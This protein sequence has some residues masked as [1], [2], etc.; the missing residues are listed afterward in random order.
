MKRICKKCNIEKELEE[1]VPNKASKDG[2]MW[3]C[4]ECN[5]ISSAKYRAKN[6]EKI[7]KQKKELYQ[8]NKLGIEKPKRI[9]RGHFTM[10]VNCFSMAD[11]HAKGV[12]CIPCANLFRFNASM[13]I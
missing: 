4:I 5:R 13:A 6:H 2:R 1:F 9:K 7:L 8:K 3:R 10:P 12:D 11:A